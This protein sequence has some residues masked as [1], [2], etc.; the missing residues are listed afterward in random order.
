M[1]LMPSEVPKTSGKLLGEA[2]EK[3]VGLGHATLPG[4]ILDVYKTQ[5]LLTGLLHFFDI[6]LLFVTPPLIRLLVDHITADSGDLMGGVACAIGLSLAP[7]VQALASCHFDV[8]SRRLGMRCMGG[9]SCMLFDKILRLSQPAAASYGAGKL[10]NIMQ[11]D[12]FRFLDTFY[13]VHFLWSM[14]MMLLVAVGMTFQ[15]LS[16]AS[17]APVIIMA[18]TYQFNKLLTTRLMMLGADTNTARDARVK[19]LTEVLHAA[20]LC[21][22]LAWER[23][24]T[25]L[26]QKKRS[27][28]ME[29]IARMK[30]W[31]MAIALLF[32]GG[33][34][35]ILQLAT[36]GI[37]VLIGGDLSP[38]LVFSSLALFDLLQ[39]PMN[40]FP[41][42]VQFLVQM[43]VGID[44]MQ[45]LLHA[46]EVS[47]QTPE[48]ASGSDGGGQSMVYVRSLVAV[49]AKDARCPVYVRAAT[50]RWASA[51]K[52]EEAYMTEAGQDGCYKRCL[53]RLRRDRR[54][55]RDPLLTN[56]AGSTE[57]PAASL[58]VTLT[59]SLAEILNG[60]LTLVVGPV[61]SGKSTFLAGILGEVPQ[62]TGRVELWGSV[63]YC[64]QVPW[65][66]HGT[67]RENIIFGK[68]LDEE[69]FQ[70]VVFACAL[71]ADLE[72]LKDGASTIIGERGINLS[73][74]QKA[75][76]GLARAAYSAA[77]VCLLDDPLSAV[78]AHV[79]AHLMDACL[80]SKGYM[81]KATRILVSHQVQFADA[82]DLVVLMRNGEV[83]AVRPPS[84]FSRDELHSAEVEASS[85]SPAVA[86]ALPQLQRS[87]SNGGNELEPFAVYTDANVPIRMP[88]GSDA[89]DELQLGAA[90]L[91]PQPKALQLRRA[92][93]SPL[94]DTTMPRPLH[95]QRASSVPLPK[96]AESNSA[97]LDIEAFVA[98]GPTPRCIQDVGD[99]SSLEASAQEEEE[100][101][102]DQEEGSVS[103]RVWCTF[104]RTM[105]TSLLLVLF[106]FVLTTG[107]N[108]GGTLWLGYWS[109][110]TD[111]IS[112]PV[113]L[114]VYAI[115]S[116][117][118]IV[119]MLGRLIIFRQTS[120][121]VSE[122]MHNRA[123][124]AV[125]R[126]P[127]WWLDTTPSG[128]VINRFSTDMQRIDVD[129]QMNMLGLFRSIFD[130]AA[131]VIVVLI[132]VPIIVVAFVP[133]LLFY[134]RL[135][136]L[137]RPCS[138]EIQRIS[139]KT[140]SPIFQGLDEAIVGVS[141]IR[142]Y[143]KSMHFSA[144]NAMRVHRNLRM[145]FTRCGCQRWLSLRLKIM[146]IGISSGVAVMVVF[147][148]Y[149]GPFGRAVSGP[150]AGLALRYAQQLCNAMEGILNSLTTV[151]QC[152]IA[153]ERVSSYT[154]LKPE[155]ELSLP[156]DEALRSWP[157]AGKIEFDNVFMRYR[158][159]LDPVLKGMTFTI[160]GGS[161]LGIVGRTGAGKSTS[162]Q[163]LFRMCELDSGSV[164]IDGIDI[165]GIGLHQ[166][167]RNLAIIPQDPV[168]FT[169]SV[170]FNLDPFG[171]HS[172]EAMWMELQK[173]QLQEF[174][175]A[176][177]EG[178]DYQLSAGG[179]NLSVGQ[180][181][182]LCSA[183]AF[184]RGAKILVL[185]EATA[186]VDFATDALI[187]DVLRTEV[188]TK[189]L[190]TVTIAHRIQTIL[191]NDLVLVV[192][193]GQ[194][195]EFGSTK[196]LAGDPSSLFY[197]F[198]HPSKDGKSTG[199][200]QA[201]T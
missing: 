102:E 137:Y 57:L 48:E 191:G 77:S 74:G 110:N 46:E 176:K 178:L 181:Q 114:G 35:A 12:T 124:W 170:R 174:F 41:I 85:T 165:S 100:Q 81:R 107:C 150:A 43:K 190:T 30:N 121:A 87:L 97:A 136:K 95:L 196:T 13:F 201:K 66:L 52:D 117:S 109:A 36:F 138:R 106:C 42:T 143:C 173:V 152:L 90:K 4:C 8:N 157:S 63:A 93:S 2:W 120:L 26:V 53:A 65:I 141:T 105:G 17:L 20:R 82:T 155:S 23:Q 118:L 161:S 27:K 61:G 49:G 131:S 116:L 115:S 76:I 9:F 158:P 145:E 172:D 171:E 47:S 195:A 33:T 140:K 55:M 154:D 45:A 3:R 91:K 139:S 39:V 194:A 200:Q 167:R 132:V 62:C 83:V 94:E 86:P 101:A 80:G 133:V 64:A 160:P 103:T 183:R 134:W 184:L 34:T 153:V 99:T 199:S 98:S 192:R 75:R 68:E 79:A 1:P 111:A 185:D 44:R 198:V 67:V 71:G 104:A 159:D 51:S 70:N 182:L 16:W 148:T 72:Q 112:I 78:D 188:A 19:I 6:S 21:K 129:L 119:F 108:L 24:I 142:A 92:L 31:Q 147:R 162:L 84:Q 126:S 28:E 60:K 169:G 7:L 197:T 59:V 189:Q 179:E 151:E 54:E 128:R 125:I 149:L 127:M 56:G 146:G 193:D 14:P 168:G 37:F 50:F 166:L 10:S 5:L 113:G 15:M 73:G 25:D 18:S 32:G 29:I 186:S 89:V 69:Q 22:M 180:R 163:A 122:A 38:G 164:K 187:Q 177:A 130:I 156:E 123:L 88:R 40:L 135:Q 11:V 144:R 175:Q 58:P 96:D